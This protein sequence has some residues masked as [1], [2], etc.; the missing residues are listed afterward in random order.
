MLVSTLFIYPIKS[1]SGI[2]VTAAQID[3]RG[4]R[5]DRRFM[6]FTPDGQAMTQHKHPQMALVEVSINEQGERGNWLN[7]WHRHRPDAALTIPL[8]GPTTCEGPRIPVTIWEDRDVL[9]VPVS[10]EADQWFSSVL[11]EPCQLVFMPP[12]THRLVDP[13]YAQHEECI[14]FTDGYPYLVIGQASLDDLNQR[15]AHPIEMRRFRPNIVVKGSE[16]YAEN[17]WTELR[18]GDQVFYP[19]APCGR[20]M[21]INIDP[22]TGQHNHEP[23]KTLATYRH[24]HGMVVF[25]QY[26]LAK[27]PIKGNL[28]SVA[29]DSLGEDGII[30]VGQSV[31][32]VV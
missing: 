29:G 12:T 32:T 7:V 20:C 9:A 1:L 24:Q 14:G 28:G 21:L 26:V 10:Q 19:G 27:P 31:T 8:D 23:L 13:A 2:S 4:L 17:D 6:L 16:P 3:G 18:I 22:I 30:Q 5:Y 15:L 11:N 25:G